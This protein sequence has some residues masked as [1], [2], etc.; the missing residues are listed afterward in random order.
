MVSHHC[1]VLA[2]PPAQGTALQPT[3]AACGSSDAELDGGVAARQHVDCR[4][5]ASSGARARPRRPP[6]VPLLPSRH[7]ALDREYLRVPSAQQRQSGPWA[8]GCRTAGT[9]H[10]RAEERI[11]RAKSVNIFSSLSSLGFVCDKKAGKQTGTDARIR[12][13]HRPMCQGQREGVHPRPTPWRTVIERRDSAGSR[14]FARL[15]GPHAQ[16]RGLHFFIVRC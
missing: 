15:R 5:S 13:D 6:P 4:G 14:A 1:S 12:T 2:R 10:A 16:G 3:Q 7:P 9:A 8:R 11:T